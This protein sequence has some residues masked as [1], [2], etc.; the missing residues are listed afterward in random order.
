MSTKETLQSLQTRL[1]ERLQTNNPSVQAGHWLGV[2]EGGHHFLLPLTQSGEIYPWSDPQL[3]SYTKQWFLGVANL[4]GMLCGVVSLSQYLALPLLPP[5]T[6]GSSTAH[7]LERRLVALH[8]AF[9]INA[10]LAVDQLLGLKNADHF[11]ASSDGL[12]LFDAQG[13]QWQPIDLATIVQS[14]H[15]L[16]IS[17]QSLKD[18]RHGNT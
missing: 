12:F 4:R 3:V 18:K 10:V 11:T 16:S 7:P 9:E 13:L 17:A 15:F 1:A 8:P 6:P 2:M 5:T 14:P